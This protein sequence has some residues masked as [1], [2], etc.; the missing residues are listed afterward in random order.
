MWISDVQC[1]TLIFTHM[2]TY[3]LFIKCTVL[4]FIY[5]SETIDV[6]HYAVNSVLSAGFSESVHIIC[7]S[8]IIKPIFCKFQSIFPFN[9]SSSDSKCL[10]RLLD[11]AAAP[12]CISSAADTRDPVGIT[13]NGRC[14]YLY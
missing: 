6:Q 3:C 8:E 11:C 2:S 13:A 1:S 7:V 12:D 10:K 5:S 9:L 4:L 14:L